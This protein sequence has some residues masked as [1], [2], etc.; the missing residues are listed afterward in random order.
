M[1][2]LLDLPLP[3]K[4]GALEPPVLFLSSPAFEV[5]RKFHDQVEI[6][7]GAH[8]KFGELPDFGA[9]IAS[10]PRE[11][12]ACFHVFQHGPTGEIAAE[13]MRAGARIAFWHLHEA[14]RIFDTVGYLGETGDAEHLLE[15]LLKRQTPASLREVLQ[16]GP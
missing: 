5:W 3:L 11:L 1:R 6:E 9:K 15:W 14:R 10:R 8:G 2:E 13:T 16:L 7:L 4:D 12:P